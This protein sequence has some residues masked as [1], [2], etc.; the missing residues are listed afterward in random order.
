MAK[1]EDGRKHREWKF[2]KARK[3]ECEVEKRGEK[4]ERVIQKTR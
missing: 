3:S 4:S 2:K 1:V